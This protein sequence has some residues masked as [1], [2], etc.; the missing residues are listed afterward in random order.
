[1]TRGRKQAAGHM[2]LAALLPTGCANPRSPAFE[3]PP[4]PIAVPV[5]SSTLHATFV[6]DE[7]TN[8]QKVTNTIR[9]FSTITLILGDDLLSPAGPVIF[10]SKLLEQGAANDLQTPVVLRIFLV[11]V[12]GRSPGLP[13][14]ASVPIFLPHFIVFLP[15]AMPAQTNEDVRLAAPPSGYSADLPSVSISGEVDGVEFSAKETLRLDGKVNNA[16]IRDLV[17]LVATDAAKSAVAASRS[18]AAGTVR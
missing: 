8:D 10:A 9:E 2:V 5:L 16:Q 11:S 7:R 18:R 17:T 4:A 12:W 15:V 13:N 14:Q 6:K 3:P 1:M